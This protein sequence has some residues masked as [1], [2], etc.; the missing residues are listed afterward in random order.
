MKPKVV[1]FYDG[2]TQAYAAVL[3]AVWMTWKDDPGIHITSRSLPDGDIDDND[4]NPDRHKFISQIVSTKARVTLLWEGL[5]VPRSEMSSLVTARRLQ[6]QVTKVM[7]ETPASFHTLRDS[8]CVI[9]SMD[10]VS[11]CL[12]PF[13]HSCMSEVHALGSKIE[14]KSI[15]EPAY[16]ISTKE[17]IT[18]LCTRRDGILANIGLGIL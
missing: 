18:D 2:S 13:M 10:Q 1:A 16:H 12:D 3:Y 8:T 14:E 5:T 4:F 17:N 6:Y 7:L 15:L 9:S 11:T